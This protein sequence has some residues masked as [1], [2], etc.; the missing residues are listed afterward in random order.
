MSICTIF[1]WFTCYENSHCQWFMP[2]L[3]YIVYI[4][5]SIMAFG[6]Q[7]TTNDPCLICIM[8]VWNDG[9]IV[10]SPFNFVI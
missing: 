5:L 7:T 2:N 9:P 4:D 8:F 1:Q 6:L 10:G 3:C